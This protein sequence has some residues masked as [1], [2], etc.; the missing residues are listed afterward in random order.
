[1]PRHLFAGK[2]T[3]KGEWDPIIKANHDA[4][5]MNQM[6]FSEIPPMELGKPEMIEEYKGFCTQM[7]EDWAC[8]QEA[9]MDAIKW[10]D[11]RE[12]KIPPVYGNDKEGRV[13]IHTPKNLKNTKGNVAII[14]VHGGGAIGG[15]PEHN[16]P[17]CC[18]SAI[19]NCAIVFNPQYRLAGSGATCD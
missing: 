18:Y 9:F 6:E 12:E 2:Y 17:A 7:Y 15:C 5:P 8:K 16:K 11:T 19:T 14:D 1:M 13:L 4:D 10:C 3:C